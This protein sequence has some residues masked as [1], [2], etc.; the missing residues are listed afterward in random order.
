MHFIFFIFRSHTTNSKMEECPLCQIKSKNGMVHHL[1][2]SH[3]SKDLIVWYSAYVGTSA[4]IILLEPKKQHLCQVCREYQGPM[5][6][7]A[8]HLAEVHHGL[9]RIW[10]LQRQKLERKLDR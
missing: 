3:F 4:F 10:A 9:A 7:L 5:D 1:A 8:E 2:R 6:I